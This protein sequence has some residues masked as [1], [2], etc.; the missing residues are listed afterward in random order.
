MKNISMLVLLLLITNAITFWATSKFYSVFDRS[1]EKIVAEI[2]LITN[3]ELSTDSYVVVDLETNKS[4]NFNLSRA[5]LGTIEGNRLQ[6]QLD[7][8][9]SDVTSNFEVHSAEKKMKIEVDCDISNQL[10]NTLDS[11]RNTF[12][13]K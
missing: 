7:P 2:E 4:V 13:V 8:K 6:I 5:F 3:C 1:Q 11:L 10:K 12:K 9:F